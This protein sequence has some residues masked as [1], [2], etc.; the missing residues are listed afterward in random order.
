MVS[1][2]STILVLALLPVAFAHAG[3]REAEERL[4]WIHRVRDSN[5]P[6]NQSM[7]RTAARCASSFFVVRIRSL[8]L[9]PALAGGRSSSH[10]ATG[11]ICQEKERNTLNDA[12]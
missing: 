11:V 10:H 3:K 4:R 12:D 1:A 9:T 5:Q 8:R 2:R 7:E 6:S